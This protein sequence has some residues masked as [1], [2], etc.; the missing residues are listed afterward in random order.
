MNS[1]PGYLFIAHQFGLFRLG[2]R[3]SNAFTDDPAR[4]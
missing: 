4:G 3:R 1:M 2:G